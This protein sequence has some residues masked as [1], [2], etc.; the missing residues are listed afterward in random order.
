MSDS[1]GLQN[2]TF[3]SFE[4]SMTYKEIQNHKKK[5]HNLTTQLINTNN[6]EEETSINDEIKNEFE[7]LSSLLKIKRNKLD[8]INKEFPDPKKREEMTYQQMKKQQQMMQQEKLQ[9]EKEEEMR[10]QKLKEINNQPQ[11][12]IQFQDRDIFGGKPIVLICSLNEKL[13]SIFERYNKKIGDDY[14]YK[15]KK[16]IYNSK[17]LNPNLTVI[18]SGIAYN[19]IIIVIRPELIG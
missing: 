6:I 4:N 19:A 3:T 18:E 1:F 9:Q 12:I 5:L 8:K 15:E 2:I 16:Y 10:Q 17:A 11:M 13:S 14:Q 7:F